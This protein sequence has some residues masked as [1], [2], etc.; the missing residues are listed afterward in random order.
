MWLCYTHKGQQRGR[1]NSPTLCLHSLRHQRCDPAITIEISCHTL[2]NSTLA[3]YND[4]W[5]WFCVFSRVCA[6]VCL[7]RVSCL[8]FEVVLSRQQWCFSCQ[9]PSHLKSIS[10]FQ[11]NQRHESP[12]WA[13]RASVLKRWRLTS[14]HVRTCFRWRKKHRESYLFS[15]FPHCISS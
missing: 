11:R 2:V 8:F 13:P 5:L 10:H 12:F 4:D 14:N 7:C 9:L 3:L 1:I 15:D 6:L